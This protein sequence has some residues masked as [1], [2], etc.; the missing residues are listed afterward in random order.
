MKKKNGLEA[1][2]PMNSNPQNASTLKKKEEK[3]AKH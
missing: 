2:F 3:K 1:I